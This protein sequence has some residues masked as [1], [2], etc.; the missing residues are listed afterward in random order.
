MADV[1]GT[2]SRL[3]LVQANGVVTDARRYS[4][5][6]F[7]SFY[8]I[9]SSFLRESDVSQVS[10]ACIAVAGPVTSKTACLTNRDWSFDLSEIA[11]VLP[12]HDANQAMLV[13]DLVALGYALS[14][15]RP[16]QLQDIRM[17]KPTGQG[18]GQSL[19]VGLGT[20]MNVCLIKEQ[21][22][23]IAVFEAEL[24]HASLPSSVE[25]AL[26]AYRRSGSR[27][28]AT[29]EDVFS[30]GGLTGLYEAAN[31]ATAPSAHQIVASGDQA[32]QQT[33]EIAAKLLGLLARELVFQYLPLNGIYF[34]GG[35]AR[36]IL[37]G[38]KRADFLSAFNETGPFV[39]LSAQVP[40]Q[41]IT[42]DA[43]ALTGA[44]VLAQRPTA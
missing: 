23:R 24:G 10:R 6:D 22:G 2:N 9:L 35:V 14:G 8:E 26:S 32:A 43:A 7:S 16:D 40:V 33:V 41:L 15:L 1:G 5:D 25:K 27:K 19:V 38:D 34:A 42:D 3:A 11:A 37:G 13:N 39:D 20:G 29:I 12:L 21:T 44:S 31:D 17:P 36:G 30:G 18:N 4:N 28:F